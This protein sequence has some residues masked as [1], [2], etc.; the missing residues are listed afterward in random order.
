MTNFDPPTT[1]YLD[2]NATTPVLPAVAQAMAECLAAG[3]ANPASGHGPGRRARQV[4]EDAREAVAAILG[5]DLG[6]RPADRLVFTSGGTEANNL[7]L[8][9]LAGEGPPGEIVVSVIEHSSIGSAA[10]RL[11][12]HGWLVHRL[13]VDASG[14]VRLSELADR[15]NR[16]TRAVAIMLA[17]NETGVLQPAAEAARICRAVGVPLHVDACQAVGKLPVDFAALGAATLSFAAHKFHG[18]LGIGG[19]VVRPDIELSPLLS[20]GFQQGGLRPGTESVVLAV[21]LYA[22]LEAYWSDAVERTSRLSALRDR[23]ESGLRSAWPHLVV[24]GGAALRGPQTVN[25][26]FVGHDRQALWMALDL[27]GVAC[28]TG[29]ACAS[30][31]SEPSPVL[32]AMGCPPEVVGSAL[33]FSL[34]ATTTAAQIDEAV[35]RI[36]RCLAQ[37]RPVTLERTGRG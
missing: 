10:Q 25:S 7:A 6:G 26:A 22:A 21:G 33:R 23:L 37:V 27:A 9:G 28:S 31:S 24:N 34:G 19:L 13:G 3:Y 20:G 8:L 5:A 16:R 32:I 17:N 15:L 14:V 1:I 11:Q 12:R 30:G 18:P 29:S 2:H 35:G 4:L 36:G